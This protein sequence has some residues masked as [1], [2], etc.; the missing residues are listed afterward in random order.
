MKLA[1]QD[2]PQVISVFRSGTFEPLDT[3]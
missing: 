2:S 1:G 3:K